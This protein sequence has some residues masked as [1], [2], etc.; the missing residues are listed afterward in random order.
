[1]K[2][3]LKMNGESGMRAFLSKKVLLYLWIVVNHVIRG[4]G[5]LYPPW[6]VFRLD[7]HSCT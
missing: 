5:R 2:D 1:M 6:K 3:I 7:M 4:K